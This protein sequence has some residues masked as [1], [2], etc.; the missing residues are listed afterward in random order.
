[1]LCWHLAC[2][3]AHLCE[4]RRHPTAGPGDNVSLRKHPAQNQ[5]S[6]GNVATRSDQNAGVKNVVRPLP[7]AALGH[8]NLLAFATVVHRNYGTRTTIGC[9]ERVHL[10]RA[11]CRCVLSPAMNLKSLSMVADVVNVDLCHFAAVRVRFDR[12]ELYSGISAPGPG[13]VLSIVGTTW[14]I[15]ATV[16]AF[17]GWMEG[18]PRGKNSPPLLILVCLEERDGRG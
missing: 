4:W 6:Y 7:I 9:I 5:R 1:M 3:E 12:A 17:R 8:L 16:D 10:P 2:N 15:R 18:W 11:N 14:I 13:A